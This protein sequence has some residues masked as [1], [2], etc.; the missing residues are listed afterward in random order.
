[1]SASALRL[2]AVRDEH[3]LTGIVV[4]HDD[5][6]STP[7]IRESLT[8]AQWYK[9]GGAA[10]RE[11]KDGTITHLMD[12]SGGLSAARANP[13]HSMLERIQSYLD[14]DVIEEAPVPVVAAPALVETSLETAK[15]AVQESGQD[16]F[17]LT[18]IYTEAD[19][20]EMAKTVKGVVENGRGLLPIDMAKLTL[21][22]AIAL[23]IVS[24]QPFS[25][26]S[27]PST[28]TPV[29]A[30]NTAPV[31]TV[32]VPV[33]ATR[34][35]VDLPVMAAADRTM[36]ERCVGGNSD[37]T[38]AL[39]NQYTNVSLTDSN[40]VVI[41]DK[42]HGHIDD[43][44]PLGY[45]PGA[46]FIR[47]DS[48]QGSSFALAY[49]IT[50]ALSAQNMTIDRGQLQI[51]S[52]AL[53]NRLLTARRGEQGGDRF[54]N[55]DEEV[56]RPLMDDLG[57]TNANDRARFYRAVWQYADRN[58][59][60][61][62]EAAVSDVLVNATAREL[63]DKGYRVWV[64]R[65]DVSELGAM[66]SDLEGRAALRR[67]MADRVALSLSAQ[68]MGLYPVLIAPHLDV[69]SRTRATSAAYNVD[70]TGSRGVSLRNQEILARSIAGAWRQGVAPETA[71]VTTEFKEKNLAIPRCS[72]GTLLES[73]NLASPVGR[74]RAYAIL[75]QEAARTRAAQNLE[76]GISGYLTQVRTAQTQAATRRA[77]STATAPR[78]A[79]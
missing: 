74:A 46:S 30:G 47:I 59:I 42:A 22:G 16:V 50:E 23:S 43:S 39:R 72:N 40:A 25:N 4:Y 32:I 12:Y 13:V 38:T 2:V 20:A 64:T 17:E 11:A 7:S 36:V 8:A 68:R 31:E 69:A 56:I 26:V 70:A 6:V 15:A 9:L 71:P 51:K 1:M 65:P 62:S 35:P 24:I 49:H 18:E 27:A 75:T 28:D 57:F 54:F 78:R 67:T 77:V 61:L 48:P 34:P 45:D 29:A 19:V 3:K 10:V 60:L 33:S 76:S 73:I 21:K 41:L 52:E 58:G 63:Q 55:A 5:G 53:F 44:L 14:G 37:A 66:T 79:A